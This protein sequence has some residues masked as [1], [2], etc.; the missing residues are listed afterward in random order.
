M[1]S[2]CTDSVGFKITLPFLLLL[3]VF[4][5]AEF[6]HHMLF[7]A[8]SKKIARLKEEFYTLSLRR[9]PGKAINFSS[10]YVLR[11]I[12]RTSEQIRTLQNSLTQVNARLDRQYEIFS[13]TSEEE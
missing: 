10:M 6:I 12:D 7:V 13:A 5:I 8:K 4:V 2:L 11:K 9:L 1:L 3:S